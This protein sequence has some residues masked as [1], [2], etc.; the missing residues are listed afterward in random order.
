VLGDGTLV[1]QMQA[2]F[3]A[4]LTFSG[5]TDEQGNVL[6]ATSL[7][8][9]MHFLTVFWKVFFALIPPAEYYGGKLAFGVA[10]IFIGAVTAIVG[11]IASLFG[12]V[13]GLDEGVTAITFVA[14]G[15]SLPDTFASK[16]AAVNEPTADNAIGNV[17]GSN[18]VNVFLGIGLPWTIAAV[19]AELTGAKFVARSNGFGLSV[20]VFV[21]L[22]SLFIGLLYYR[23]IVGGA[24]LGGKP[25]RFI[26]NTTCSMVH[27]TSCFVPLIH[28]MHAGICKILC[29]YCLRSMD[30]I[31]RYVLVAN[32][33]TCWRPLDHKQCRSTTSPST[34]VTTNSLYTYIAHCVLYITSVPFC[35][36]A[37]I[38]GA[39]ETKFVKELM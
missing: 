22:A 26:I 25:V 16:L 14:L 7:D 12:C 17:T 15:T 9:F 21:V 4:A 27:G 8:L 32:V 24:E 1:L 19:Y 29:I 3:Q 37:S 23:R 38:K 30:S 39:A 18:S 35:R 36:Y 13:V 10:L 20:L 2:Q 5:P 11:E 28:D 34:M 31:C 6:P 33:W